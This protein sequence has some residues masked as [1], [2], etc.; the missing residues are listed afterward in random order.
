MQGLSI[1]FTAERIYCSKQNERF[2]LTLMGSNE[3]VIVQNNRPAIYAKK[4][5]KSVQWHVVEGTVQDKAAL[6]PVYQ[7]LEE[8]INNIPRV[9]Q[10]TL[11]FI[12]KL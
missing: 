7:K 3:S 11:N 4:L 9:L 1:T 10:G 8:T 2:R 5:N 6:L 12:D